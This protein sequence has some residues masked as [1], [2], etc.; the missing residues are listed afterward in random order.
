MRRP[1]GAGEHGHIERTCSV[2][3][4]QKYLIATLQS[5]TRIVIG[6]EWWPS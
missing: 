1:E 2:T 4:T 6:V 5:K 3:P